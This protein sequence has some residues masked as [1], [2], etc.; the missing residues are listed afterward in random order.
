[1]DRTNRDIINSFVGRAPAFYIPARIPAGRF[2][3]EIAGYPGLLSINARKG[4]STDFVIANWDAAS[5]NPARPDTVTFQLRPYIPLGTMTAAAEDNYFNRGGLDW[6]IQVSSGAS[7]ITIQVPQSNR[8]PGVWLVRVQYT[9]FLGTQTNRSVAQLLIVDDTAP[10]DRSGDKPPPPLAPVGMPLPLTRANFLGAPGQT[11]EFPVPYTLADGLSDDDTI[12]VFWDGRPVDFPPT[13]RR[14]PITRATPPSI[15]FPLSAYDAHPGN[16]ELTYQII[17]VT[18]NLSQQSYGLLLGDLALAPPPTGFQL[19]TVDSAV[20]GDG[21]IDRIDMATS[22]GAIVRVPAIQ[23]I[24]PTDIITVNLSNGVT[25]IP[26]PLQANAFP[27]PIPFQFTQAD[28]ATLYGAGPGTV[29]LT[30]SYSVTR[31]GVT[32]PATPLSVNFNLDL[33]LVGPNP[34]P[35]PNVPNTDLPPVV[36]N[37]LRPG[38][39][40]GPNNTLELEDVNRDAQAVIPL[41]TAPL[42]LTRNCRSS[43]SYIM[44]LP[45]FHRR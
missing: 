22:N 32:L 25:T 21:L 12:A 44:V 36:V 9:N 33:F 8:P 11:L 4:Q 28:L 35:G 37:A 39:L 14:L 13:G 3:G 23:N 10:F 31:G 19:P 7:P 6:Q 2:A 38:G 30:A 15:P 20:P 34:N 26:R 41:W 27:F 45:L 43:L 16:Y 17:D 24:L 40:L 42:C 29:P 5:T 18:G 1:M